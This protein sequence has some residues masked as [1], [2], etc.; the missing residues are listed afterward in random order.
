MAQI[1]NIAFFNRNCLP[2]KELYIIS[3]DNNNSEVNIIK[4]IAFNNKPK[5]PNQILIWK[6][7]NWKNYQKK[8]VKFKTQRYAT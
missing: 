1:H 7:S 6:I 3:E 5:K 4:Q 8:N 2:Y